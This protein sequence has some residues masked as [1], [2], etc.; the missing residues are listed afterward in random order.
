VS[1]LIILLA[2]FVLLWAVLIRPQRMKQRAQ[3]QMLSQIDPGDEILTVGG[4][5]G[6]VVEVE[7]D[8]DLVVEIADGIHVRIARRAVATVDK[9]EEDEEAEAETDDDDLVVEIADGI[10]VRIARR[11]VAT[12]DKPEEE[13]EEAEADDDDVVEA[14]AQDVVVDDEDVEGLVTVPDSEATVEATQRRLFRRR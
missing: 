12:V 13:D 14:D 7:D 5:Y 10:H 1:S 6:I 3:Q 11:A 4:I 9:P 2:M 8:D